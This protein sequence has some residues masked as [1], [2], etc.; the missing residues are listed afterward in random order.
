MNAPYFTHSENTKKILKVCFSKAVHIP[1]IHCEQLFF[2][3]KEKHSLARIQTQDQEHI[4]L[5]SDGFALSLCDDVLTFVVIL[6]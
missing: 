4:E 5:G 6:V 2:S 1:G 3:I